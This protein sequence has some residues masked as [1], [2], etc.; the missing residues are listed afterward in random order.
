MPSILLQTM[1]MTANHFIW[2]WIIHILITK[3]TERHFS[4]TKSRKQNELSSFKASSNSVLTLC[5]KFYNLTC[6]VRE[7]GEGVGLLS[8]LA[9]DGETSQ[10]TSRTCC[11]RWEEYN[12][13]I[14]RPTDDLR[15][16]VKPSKPVL[17][18][19]TFWTLSS[20]R[21]R[22]NSCRN[23][24]WAKIFQN[25]L[26]FNSS[27]NLIIGHPRSVVPDVLGWPW[28]MT[29]DVIKHK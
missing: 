6:R 9:A 2:H 3:M 15:G 11:A 21:K 23:S 13:T 28:H 4:Y 27:K 24:K 29:D 20:R 12:D 26:T 5:A 19:V 16:Q 14:R 22:L 25:I 18:T 10:K 7:R 17:K 1:L 8:C